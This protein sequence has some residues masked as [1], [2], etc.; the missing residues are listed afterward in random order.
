MP[1]TAEEEKNIYWFYRYHHHCRI[2][3]KF[4]FIYNQKTEKQNGNKTNIYFWTIE[5]PIIMIFKF[6]SENSASEQL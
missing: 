3:N 5:A 1:R 4:V 2:E 6:N